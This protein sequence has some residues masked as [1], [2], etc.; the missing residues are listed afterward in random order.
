MRVTV[1]DKSRQFDRQTL[2]Y[3]EYRAF[4]GLASRCADTD[5]VTVTLA[6]PIGDPVEDQGLVV[7]GIAVLAG[8]G[9]VFEVETV[10]RHPCAA[11]D[12][13]V[14]LIREES[15]APVERPVEMARKTAAGGRL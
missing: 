9:E 8:T 5:A 14:S 2:A 13:A 1:R 6:R 3:A 15:R 12:R 10:A 11:V 7:C 4:E